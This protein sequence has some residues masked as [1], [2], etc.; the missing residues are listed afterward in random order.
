MTQ[1]IEEEIVFGG[2]VGLEQ[3]LA[4]GN[5]LLRSEPKAAAAQARE[6]L[7]VDPVEGDALRLLAKAL[8]RTGQDAE[9]EQAELDA[10]KASSHNPILVDAAIALGERRLNA[11]EHLLRPYLA[12]KP[13]DAAALRM[14]AEIA[15]RVGALPDAEK[16]LREALEL[17]PGYTSARLRLSAVLVQRNHLAES[18]AVLD[19]LI[20]RD[21]ESAQA[22]GT[23]AATLGRLGDYQ[24][25]LKLYE[26]LL[27]R[28]PDKPG[29]WMSYGH[30][31]NTVG[32]L[33]DCISAYRR[34][35]ALNPHHGEAWWSLANLKTVRL[36]SSD[37][38]QMSAA[39]GTPGLD[40]DSR[41][42]LHFALGKA[43][44]DAGEHKLSF[45]NYSEAN[46]LRR[47]GSGYSADAT[48]ELVLRCEA[49]FSRSLF[50]AREGSGCP[51]P[52]PI[53]VLGMPRAGSTLI[54]QILSSHSM[55]E[56]T[57]ELPHMPALARRVDSEREQS[58]RGIYPEWAADLDAEERLELGEEY[59]RNAQLHRKTGKPFFIDK[60]PNN[61]INIG[62][63]QLILPKARII[64]ARR[65]PLGC[66]FSNF[67]QNFARGQAFTYSL[68]DLGRYYGDY[69][70]LMHHF[71][72]V[73]PGRIH[74][75]FH[76]A[77]V[78]DSEAEIR[79]ML[80]YLGLPFEESCLRFYEND[81]AVRTPSAEQVRR[82]INRE[83]VEQWKAYEPWL[84][85]L[86]KSLGPVL[87][88]Y[89][90]VPDDS[91]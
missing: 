55:I 45:E 78:E 31:L 37:V 18:L 5:R 16:L 79:A 73:L 59:L 46:R 19:E 65:H 14:L 4:N 28:S 50:D 51:A 7:K 62:L 24:E 11:A 77:M 86:K 69:V 15:A 17:A 3:A 75:V 1:D 52:D 41:L 70:R 81:R 89:P 39:L 35:I 38:A 88:C 10:I 80:D 87:E 83:G 60:L 56:G 20:G 25:A 64:D 26:E 71:D 40:D 48:T 36:D 44:E 61:W 12:R 72:E 23:K 9:A 54:E 66:C 29:I 21:P 34:A 67:K 84:G 82:P 76:E 43:Y 42:H 68:D 90:D 58:G 6:I 49:V 47:E 22:K 30:L 33:E 74:R 63:I 2:S 57:S 13:D 8:R 91:D 53:F 32:R 27:E 85:P